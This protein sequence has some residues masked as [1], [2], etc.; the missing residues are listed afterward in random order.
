MSTI[1]F[2]TNGIEC[3]SSARMSV[4]ASGGREKGMTRDDYFRIVERVRGVRSI[5]GLRPRSA[6]FSPPSCFKHALT[7]IFHILS[8]HCCRKQD[9]VEK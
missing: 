2:S 7:S 4:H 9:Q 3:W 1:S 5:F 8:Y 6:F